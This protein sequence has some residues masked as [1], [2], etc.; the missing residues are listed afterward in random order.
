MTYLNVG[1]DGATDIGKLLKVKIKSFLSEDLEPGDFFMKG[2]KLFFDAPAIE[3]GDDYLASVT[4][5]YLNKKGKE[6][7]SDFE[8]VIQNSD[9]IKSVIGGDDG[10]NTLSWTTKKPILMYGHDG[11][12]ILKSGT[13]ND[14][15]YGGDGD[16]EI[17]T[18]QGNDEIMGG[19]GNDIIYA[20]TGND[21]MNGGDGDDVIWSHGGN[22]TMTGGDG[23]DSFAILTGDGADIIKDFVAGVD[24]IYLDELRFNE[25]QFASIATKTATG[26][27]LTFDATTSVLLEGVFL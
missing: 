19:D 14:K 2:K 3:F 20:G 7:T 5:T 15:V 17:S 12:D 21:L 16:D 23:I 26:T 8:V 1:E 25:S 10:P 27:L 22:D 13:G 9:G 18:Y 24:K 4:I 11:D 6:L